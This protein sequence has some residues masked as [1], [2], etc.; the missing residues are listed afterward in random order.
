MWHY[1]AWV[2]SP[3]FLHQLPTI[4]GSYFPNCPHTNLQL[5]YRGNDCRSSESEYSCHAWGQSNMQELL[6]SELRKLLW[7]V[8]N[9][10]IILYSDTQCPCMSLFLQYF[11]SSYIYINKTFWEE[12][13]TFLWY[14]MDSLENEKTGGCTDRRKDSKVIWKASFYFFQ[15]W[16]L[17]EK[18]CNGNSK[19][20]H[21]RSQC[22]GRFLWPT[23]YIHTCNGKNKVW[24]YAIL[25][26]H[27]NKL[28][29]VN[30]LHEHKL[31]RS[32]KYAVFCF[33][34]LCLL[35]EYL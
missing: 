10:I 7:G 28:L 23:P 31:C 19:I 33:S 24:N 32:P 29:N 34:A 18:S 22:R 27:S 15:I 16:K 3:P 1:L 6:W 30:M 35:C 20:D 25:G 4:K 12:L 8:N 11:I 26:Y 9:K 21:W 14:D 13:S 5:W 17:A 2:S